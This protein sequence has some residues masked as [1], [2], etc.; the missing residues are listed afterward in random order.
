[1]QVSQ[2]HL[3]YAYS[4]LLDH[5]SLLISVCIYVNI[6]KHVH[7]FISIFGKNTS[8]IKRTSAPSIF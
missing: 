7:S 5:F 2:K 6:F 1:M 4:S 3:H 8:K